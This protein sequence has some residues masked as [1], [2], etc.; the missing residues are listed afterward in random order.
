MWSVIGVSGSLLVALCLLACVWVG[1][2]RYL[3]V[4]SVPNCCRLKTR[5]RFLFGRP[6]END[7]TL[8]HMLR[9]GDVAG[10]L[11]GFEHVEIRCIAGRLVRLHP[12]L[13]ANDI[14][15]RAR[16]P[17]PLRTLQ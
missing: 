12:R 3:L 10:L 13:F 8:L 14:A 16:K 11:G 6:P 5:L 9:P 2:W 4:G 17:E 7:P 15:F 1:W